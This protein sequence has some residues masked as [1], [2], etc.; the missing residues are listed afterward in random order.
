MLIR[1]GDAP[2]VRIGSSILLAMI[3]AAATTAAH[4]DVVISSDPTQNMN[5]SGGV[6]SPTAP[7]AILNAT[8]LT[9]M[10]ASGNVKVTNGS[11]AVNIVVRAPLAWSTSSRLTLEADNSLIE[12][13]APILVQGRGGLD[14]NYNPSGPGGDLIFANG[15]NA[16]F[17]D[18][19]SNLS[20]NGVRYTLVNT[21]SA[22]A[23]G[24]HRHPSDHYALANDY[25]A[26]VDGTYT[27]IPVREI[28]GVFE[29]LGHT[30]SNLR[31]TTGAGN[32]AALIDYNE[33]TTRD[34]SLVNEVVSG[35][36]SDVAGLAAQNSGLVTYV[37]V[38]GTV[39]S[40]GAAELAIV[41]GVI[42]SSNGTVSH[43]TAAVNVQAANLPNFAVVGGLVGDASGANIVDCHATG[44]VVV[45]TQSN[46]SYY[47]G[48]LV[49]G[50]LNPSGSP[51]ISLSSASG[52]VS[53]AGNGGSFVG[54]LAGYV[55]TTTIEQSYATGIVSG[56]ASDSVGGLVG[57]G[58]LVHDSYATGSVQGGAQAKVG[59][60]AGSAVVRTSYSTGAV[61]AGNTAH[62]SG[63]PYVGG[64][65][66][67]WDRLFSADYWDVDTSGTNVGCGTRRKH[68]R[69]VTGLTDQQLKSALP[70]GFSKAIWGQN[71]S[72]NNGYPYLLANPPQ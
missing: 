18:L 61:S 19:N 55:N 56:G 24:L 41:G 49:G 67:Y 31:I 32:S 48:G 22:L 45:Q 62:Q 11:G 26:S 42:G 52:S 70:K 27:K 37:S 69:G 44:S 68:C 7:N 51:S 33:G 64:F 12:V 63:P 10:L 71:P 72:I 14:F 36:G 25:D 59:G 65:V 54:G 34:V 3:A 13:Q 8:D 40:S 47:V 2:M 6:C 58:D 9:N 15:G 46:V 21:I 39:R 5:C 16:T 35:G 28:G 53:A 38:S 23:R 4:A 43:A 60:L 66:V 1:A 20:I 17:S 50:Y 30:I 29:G 57:G